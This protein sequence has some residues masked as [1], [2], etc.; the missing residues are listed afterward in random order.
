MANRKTFYLVLTFSIIVAKGF[1]QFLYPFNDNFNRFYVFD[2][3]VFEQLE[4][5]PVDEYFVGN[6]YLAYFDPRGRFQLYFGGEKHELS[7]NRPNVYATDHFLAY[8]FGSQ[9]FLLEGNKL[10]QIESWALQED[11]LVSDS[12]IAYNDVYNRFNVYQKDS[13]QTIESWN[14]YE[15]SISNN[16]LAYLD[17]NKQLKIFSRGQQFIVWPTQPTAFLAGQNLVAFQTGIGDLQV[18]YEDE[19]YTLTYNTNGGFDVSDELVTYYDDLGGFNVFYKGETY[20]LLPYRPLTSELKENQLVWSDRNGFFYTFYQGETIRL[21][22]YT[23]EKTTIDNE[24]I[25]Y[26]DVN[27]RLK[28]FA[29]GEKYP[30]SSRIALDFDQFNQAVLYRENRFRWHINIQGEDYTFE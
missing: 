7:L 15:A 26:Q 9:I 27:G 5:Q 21:E 3:G 30:I 22:S 23:P 17:I 2:S 1:G 14:I 11:L 16:S 12:I 20:P 8:Q 10:H 4:F 19:L 13:S 25:V 24:L 18:W 29:Q 6:A 28:G